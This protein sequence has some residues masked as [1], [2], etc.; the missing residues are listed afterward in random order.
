MAPETTRRTNEP[1]AV[2]CE[3]VPVETWLVVVALEKSQA[4][5]LN[6]VAVADVV[7]CQQSEV[8][9][10]LAAALGV[11]TCVVDS[12][13]SGRTFET[14]FVGHVGLGTNDG[15][16]S[17]RLALAV[18]V[19]HAVHVPVVG[20]AERRLPVGNGR[21]HQFVE[22]RCAVEHRKLGVNVEVCE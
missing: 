13:P 20:D 16:D 8:V 21:T 22:T 19:E 6:E 11:A 5:E 10:Q 3:K 17:L 2:L 7:F 9:V 1:L 15:L 18:E 12:T 4:G 14:R